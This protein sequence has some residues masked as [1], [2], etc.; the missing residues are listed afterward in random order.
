VLNV[1]STAQL[2][3]M[4]DGFEPAAEVRENELFP[5]ESLAGSNWRIDS[6]HASPDNAAFDPLITHINHLVNCDLRS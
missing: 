1:S 4:T 3:V 2:T 6:M 5:P